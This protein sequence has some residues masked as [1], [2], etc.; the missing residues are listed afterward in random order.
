MAPLTGKLVSKTNIE[1]AGDL[2]HELW[3]S[4]PQDVPNMLPV[5]HGC[6]LHEGEFGKAEF[7]VSWLY[8]HGK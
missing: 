4:T 8:M 3:S 5:V 2:F 6:D 7:V 1:S